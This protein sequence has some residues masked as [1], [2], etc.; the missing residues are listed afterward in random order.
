MRENGERSEGYKHNPVMWRESRPVFHREPAT[1]L[2]AHVQTGGRDVTRW[3]AQSLFP[4]L[5]PA[6]EKKIPFKSQNT[7]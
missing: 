5:A 6:E 4:V 1:A 3:R 2:I 7:P